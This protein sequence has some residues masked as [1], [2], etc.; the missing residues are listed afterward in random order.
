M[1]GKILLLGAAALIVMPGSASA[2][3]GDP[4]P[5][6]Y[7]CTFLPGPISTGTEARGAVAAVGGQVTHVYSHALSGFSAHMSATAM[8]KLL[9][10]NPLIKGCT[11]DRVASIPPTTIGAITTRGGPPTGGGGSTQTVP[12]GV[13]RVGGPGSSAGTAW[14][15]DTGIDLTHPDLNVST[16]DS[17]SFVTTEPSPNDRNGHGTHVA[18]I[19][20]AKDNG[21][22]VVGVAAGA[23]VVAVKVLDRTGNGADSDVIAGIN[24]V[25]GAGHAGDVIN[26]SLITTPL[27]EMDLAVQSAAAAGF[28]IAIAAGNSSAN[29]GNYSPARANGA[30]IYTVS[31]IDSKDVFASYS[32]WGNPPVDFAEPGSSILSTYKNGTCATLSGTSMAAPHLAGILLLHNGAAPNAG[33]T[34]IS[35]PD[36]NADVIGVK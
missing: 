24:H 35:D 23:K 10:K 34:A 22:G 27:A 32:N 3:A 17:V 8:Q 31:A 20:G 6:S 29:A 30:G 33:G 1:I 2:K 12:W 25:V 13:K 21:I 26:L 9:A 18:G 5:G 11:Q 15:I 19:I 16:A 4:I 28:Y 7:I 14:I 36:K